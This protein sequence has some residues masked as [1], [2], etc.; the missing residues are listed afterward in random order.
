MKPIQIM[1]DEDLLKAFDQEEEV[2][3]NGRSAVLRR[4]I[5]EYLTRRRR[6]GIAADYIRAY[7]TETNP[8]GEEFD[9]WKEEGEWPES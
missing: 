5:A 4:I 3:K 6:R 2:L 8:L 9:G 1:M 7:G